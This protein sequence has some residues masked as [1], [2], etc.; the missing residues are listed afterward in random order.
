MADEATTPTYQAP[1]P[2][3]PFLEPLV[4]SVAADWP[5]QLEKMRR[6][7][8]LPTT[9][10]ARLARDVAT[11]YATASQ[12]AA[13]APYAT[14]APGS[15]VEGFASIWNAVVNDLDDQLKWLTGIRPDQRNLDHITNADFAVLLGQVMR[16]IQFKVLGRKLSELD[17]LR[18]Y[19]AQLHADWKPVATADP[20]HA[21]T[22]SIAVDRYNWLLRRA[23]FLSVKKSQHIDQLDEIN[24]ADLKRTAAVLDYSLMHLVRALSFA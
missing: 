23:R 14:L 22:S 13:T 11:L 21:L 10:L 2:V 15:S 12:Q 24:L 19:T 6:G 18:A 1:G 16:A 7:E 5:R 17:Y 4:W 20:S 8:A 9:R 3:D